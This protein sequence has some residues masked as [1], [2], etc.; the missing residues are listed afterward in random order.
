MRMAGITAPP[1]IVLDPSKGENKDVK[2]E[3]LTRIDMMPGIS[4]GNKD[5]L[6]PSV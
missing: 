2:N 5:K 4:S 3:V 1:T 6:A